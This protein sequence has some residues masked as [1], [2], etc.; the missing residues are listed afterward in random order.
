M[1][2]NRK[3]EKQKLGSWMLYHDCALTHLA[4]PL[5]KEDL[6]QTQHSTDPTPS[7]LLDLAPSHILCSQTEKYLQGKEISESA[8]DHPMCNV[9]N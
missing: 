1:E 3:S 2:I 5:H 9:G 8:R 4:L 7:D 6:N